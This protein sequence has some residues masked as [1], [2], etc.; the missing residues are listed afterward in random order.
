MKPCHVVQGTFVQAAGRLTGNSGGMTTDDVRSRVLAT[1]EYLPTDGA[2]FHVCQHG[3]SDAPALLLIHGT[4]ASA[5]SWDP[6]LP[7]LS[8]HR[9]I[10]IDLLGCGGSAVP[11]DGNYAVVDQVPRIG[12][13]L[14]ELGVGSVVVVGHSSGGIF[15]TALTEARP[16]LVSAVVMIN[17][18]PDMS[19]YIAKEVSMQGASWSDLTDDQI[20]EATSDGFHPGYDIPQAYLEQFR[21]IDFQAFGAISVA[22]RAYLT[23]RSLPDRLVPLGKPLLVIFGDQD[24]RWQPSSANDYRI[25]PG[26]VINMMS[27]LGHSP[28]L[29]DPQRTARALLGFI[30]AL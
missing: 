13:V 12:V 24:L 25:V 19:A 16:D 8:T 10:G 23:Q 18:G 4:A 26:A 17:T 9:V 20:R 28:N 14:D 15:A 29:E 11:D 2:E 30:G 5:R 6:M 27:G 22:I 21:E 1:D 7:L 3:P